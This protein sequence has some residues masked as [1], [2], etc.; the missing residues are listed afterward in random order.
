M[1]LIL[2]IIIFVLILLLHYLH[3]EKFSPEYLNHKSSCFSCE[4]DMINRCGEDCAWK[5]NPSKGFDDEKEAVL[6]TGNISGGF[7]AKTIKY[8]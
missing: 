5:A 4:K 8:Y 2:F 7:L 1:I 6:Q 3:I